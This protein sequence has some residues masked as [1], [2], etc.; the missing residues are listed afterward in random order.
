MVAAPGIMCDECVC[1]LLA[2]VKK[3]LNFSMHASMVQQPRQQYDTS[4][5]SAQPAE[6]PKAQQPSTETVQVLFSAAREQNKTRQPLP[7][8]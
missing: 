4:V 3:S 8:V 6:E 1:V 2:A 5:P 7:D